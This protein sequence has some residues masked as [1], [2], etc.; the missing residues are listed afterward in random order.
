M[1]K[2]ILLILTWLVA[3]VAL[4]KVGTVAIADIYFATGFKNGDFVSVN[5]AVELN[6]DEPAYHRNLGLMYAVTAKVT[7]DKELQKEVAV[8]ADAEFT[9]AIDLNNKNLLTL[10]AAVI[11]YQELGEVLKDYLAKAEEVTRM[12][13]TLSPTDPVGALPSL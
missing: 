1:H 6:G 12:I 9:R 10:K 3:A 5:K 11:G 7:S 4:W 2:I 8:A 13:K